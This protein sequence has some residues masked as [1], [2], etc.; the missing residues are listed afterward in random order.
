MP[1]HY[2]DLSWDYMIDAKKIKKDD[3]P[4][5]VCAHGLVHP[6]YAASELNTKEGLGGNERWGEGFCDFMRGTILTYLGMNGVGRWQRSIR[7]ARDKYSK[8]D[9]PASCFVMMFLTQCGLSETDMDTA[10]KDIDALASFVQ[11]LFSSY[12]NCSLENTIRSVA[13]H[14]QFEIA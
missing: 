14:N 1:G 3:E 8:Y 11:Q 10:I 2:V 13:K 9:T 4:I 6:F 12:R 5:T 7:S